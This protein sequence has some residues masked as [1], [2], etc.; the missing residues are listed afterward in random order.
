MVLF[1]G[2]L[3]KILDVPQYKIR[4][5]QLSISREIATTE[6]VMSFEFRN[7]EEQIKLKRS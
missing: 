1:V 5:T 3:F 2:S 7:H 4:E 6:L